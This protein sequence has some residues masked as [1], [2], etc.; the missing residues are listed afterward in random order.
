MDV[1][2][3]VLRYF[4]TVAEELHFTRAAERLYLSQPAL[5]R[6]IRQLE[7][8]LGAPLFERT[9]REVRLTP[10]GRALLPAAQRITAAWCSG[11]RAA[12]S[13]RAAQE[14]EVRLGFE[15]TG[16]GALTTRARMLFERRNPG[17]AVLPHRFGW[18]G[19]A[20]AL[21]EG[22]VDVAFIW[23][24]N[25]LTGLRT[26]VVA[27]E[28]RVV[29]V[30]A[31]HRLAG[32]EELSIGDLRGEPL[33]W[34]RNAPREWVDWWAVV[35][36]PDGSEPVWGPANDSAEELLEYV[37]SGTGVCI[38]SRSISAYY[39]RP[40]IVWRPLAGV[41]P[42]RIALGWALDSEHPLVPDFV[43]AVRELVAEGV[44][45]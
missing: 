20:A 21:R 42:L 38:V 35:P 40:D 15:A 17:S 2:T 12:R 24:P 11:K 41:E 23:L 29:G 5:S 22:E 18:G 43:R 31:G 25:D 14:R 16:A 28:P 9:S 19:E 4:T 6:Q 44:S 34:A 37:A 39:R 3:R 45:V 8:D 36:R 1:D 7:K 26:E 10:A 13:A 33:P 30:A 27:E 32:R